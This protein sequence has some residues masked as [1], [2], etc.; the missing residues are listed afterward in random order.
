MS[1]RKYITFRILITIILA[2]LAGIAGSEGGWW[3]GL[4]LIVA[5]ISIFLFIR[6][7]SP[8]ILK[9]AMTDERTERI[10]E[11]AAAMAIRIFFPA[12][13][14]IGASLVVFSYK[15]GFDFSQVGITLIYTVFALAL[16]VITLRFHYDREF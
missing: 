14:V 5:A 2:T 11:K 9:E 12:V 15:A 4:L 7:L 10:Q 3:W 13:M 8:K 1:K 6:Y 16:L